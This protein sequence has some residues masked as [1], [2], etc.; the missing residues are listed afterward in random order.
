MVFL[1]V[2]NGLLA[3]TI[4]F[5]WTYIAFFVATFFLTAAGLPGW[6]ALALV[7]PL[8]MILTSMVGVTLERVAAQR[9][10][11]V[12]KDAAESASRAK[13][14]FVANIAENVVYIVR[15]EDVRHQGSDAEDDA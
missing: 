12:A 7:V 11:N 8:T 3:S 10:L 5:A 2:V 14:A 9:E 15:G 13:S 1:M 4:L 6:A